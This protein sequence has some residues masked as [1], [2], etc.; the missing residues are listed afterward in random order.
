MGGGNGAIDIEKDENNN[1]EVILFFKYN[2][3][4]IVEHEILHLYQSCRRKTI[5]TKNDKIFYRMSKID[6]YF[7]NHNRLI[8]I[9]NS[10]IYL[11]LD[12]EI[13][14][15]TQEVYRK[16]KKDN[17][18]KIN[19]VDKI[20][21][22]DEYEISQILIDSWIIKRIR[23]KNIVNFVSH[24]LFF[25]KNKEILTK[26]NNLKKL[27]NLYFNYIGPIKKPKIVKKYPV[28]DDL[29][30]NILY[31]EV[32]EKYAEDFIN[33]WEKTFKKQGEKFKRKLIKLYNN[34]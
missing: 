13:D 19:F 31:E 33:K 32:S 30:K 9:L 26:E 25:Y 20:K 3:L 18:N 29:T 2:K 27:N 16:L 4:H 34:L 28:I 6:S 22:T 1:I 17:V 21:N 15:R 12:S 14:A 10:Y 11:S 24:W 7:N 23:K 5:E 8:R